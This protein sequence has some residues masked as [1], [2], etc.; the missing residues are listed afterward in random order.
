MIA[1]LK[2]PM[3]VYLFERMKPM[4]TTYRMFDYHGDALSMPLANVSDPK[5]LFKENRQIQRME[6]YKRKRDQ[7]IWHETYQKTFYAKDFK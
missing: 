6:V 3:A 5:Q 1:T 7:S 2:R 4:I